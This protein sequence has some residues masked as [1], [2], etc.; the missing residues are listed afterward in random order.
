MHSQV[1][2]ASSP[3][4][5]SQILQVQGSLVFSVVSVFSMFSS[6]DTSNLVCAVPVEPGVD[7]QRVAE[8]RGVPHWNLSSPGTSCLSAGR[9]WNIFAQT[10]TC[11][12]C[13]HTCVRT[14]NSQQL[15]LVLACP[16]RYWYQGR[17]TVSM[18][19]TTD[20]DKNMSLVGC[21]LKSW[22]FFYFH[23]INHSQ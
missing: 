1:S 20:V 11:S 5:S 14:S 21:V 3:L 17:E 6:G 19:M 22:C 12:Y 9:F 13:G 18:Y 2:T 23:Y 10:T 7:S 8:A 16:L 4:Y 15:H